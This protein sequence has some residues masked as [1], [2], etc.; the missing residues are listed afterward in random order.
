ML[1]IFFS[2]YIDLIPCILYTE[3]FEGPKD[4]GRMLRESV[5]QKILGKVLYLRH[6]PS[7][8]AALDVPVLPVDKNEKEVSS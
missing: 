6:W 2:I 1:Y 8:E 5:S 7:I 3:C 4:D